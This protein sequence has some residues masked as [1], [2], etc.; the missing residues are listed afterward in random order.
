MKILMII[1]ALMLVAGIALC[2]V[3]LGVCGFVSLASGAT[4]LLT[5]RFTAAPARA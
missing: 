5:Q 1:A 4:H 2:D 3:V